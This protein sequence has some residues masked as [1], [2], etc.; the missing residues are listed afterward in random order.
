MLDKM[1]EK[2]ILALAVSG[3]IR[4]VTHKDVGDEDVER[5]VKAFREILR[6]IVREIEAKSILNP[7]KIYDYCVNP[8]TGCQVG[9][10]YCY[11]ALFMRRYSGH[12]EPWGEFVDVKVNA[13]GPA[14]Q[15]D[16]QGRSGARSGSPRSAIPIS[17]SKSAM[18]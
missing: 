17:R 3:G 2:G 13:P 6:L 4:M 15:A 16:R 1:K 12:S 18:P 10:V 11:A 8:Y 5:A 14:G 9:C 7:S